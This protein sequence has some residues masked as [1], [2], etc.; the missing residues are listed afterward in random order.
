MNTVVHVPDPSATI[1]CFG[2]RL[3]FFLTPGQSGGWLTAGVLT[4]PPGN[5]PPVHIH[6]DE[7][8]MLTVLEGRFAFF[9]DGT[10][11]AGGPGTSV[12][13]PRGQ[14]HAF[15]NI[16]E[17]SGKLQVLANSSGLIS[18]FQQCEVP[19]HLSDGPDM[20]TITAIAAAH[21]IEFV[22]GPSPEIVSNN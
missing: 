21:G 3:Q 13:L 8:E 22:E 4:A 5:G 6:R 15:R 16:G 12:F 18:F 10:W 17:T 2:G 11:T 19:F 9:A 1:A 20:A 14:A 7:D